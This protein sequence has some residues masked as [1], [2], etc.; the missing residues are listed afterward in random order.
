LAQEPW[1]EESLGTC[2]DR[3]PA[4]VVAY[5]LVGA[6]CRDTASAVN[7][8]KLEKASLVQK[9]EPWDVDSL[10]S[11]KDRKPAHVVEFPNV[12]ANCDPK[13]P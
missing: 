12:G 13:K 1:D 8:E 9:C 6:N 5:P 10:G 3:K 11:C 2:K 7:G 4:H